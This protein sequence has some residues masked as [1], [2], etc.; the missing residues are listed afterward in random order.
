VEI[1]YHCGHPLTQLQGS[2]GVPRKGTP[3]LAS[4]FDF[5]A[6]QRAGPLFTEC[7]KQKVKTI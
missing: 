4:G 1:H 7:R 3:R 2:S 6:D 5:A